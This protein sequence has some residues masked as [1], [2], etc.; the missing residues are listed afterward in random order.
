M[1]IIKEKDL[2]LNML[3]KIA[4]QKFKIK[5]K[6]LTLSNGSALLETQVLNLPNDTLIHIS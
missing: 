2:S 4:S 5:A 1:I 6:Q 3:L